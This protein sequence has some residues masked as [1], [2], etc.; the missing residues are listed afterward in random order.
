[1]ANPQPILLH[2]C[3]APCSS[4]IIEW[5]LNN[6]IRPTL[7]YCNPNI[8]PE[9]EYLI[10]KNECTKY[11]QKLGLDIIDDDY[12]H[13]TWLTSIGGLENEPE[14]GKRCL[15]CFKIRLL[16]TARKAAELGIPSFT[17]TLASSRWKSL[18]QI[19]EAGHWAAS[20]VPGTSFNDRNWRKGGLQQRRNELLKENGFYNQLYC[21]CEFSLEAAKKKFPDIFK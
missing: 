4:A 21:G 15:Q 18:D 14:R 5:M 6:D 13:T 11:A 2:C 17:T 8:Y 16:R 7:Y 12:D 3:C 19:N 20:Q 1:M 10:R 9:Q